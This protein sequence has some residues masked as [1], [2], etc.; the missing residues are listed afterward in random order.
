M[1]KLLTIF[2]IFLSLK[3][4]RSMATHAVGA[5]ITYQCLGGNNYRFF[6]TLYRD[7]SGI[8][9]NPQYTLGG[10]SSC[11]G[12][13]SIIVNLDSTYEV[14]HTCSTVITTCTNS[15]STY[16]GVQANYYHGDITLPS[17]C[18]FWTF[19]LSPAICNRNLAIN[20]LDTSNGF[21]C[22]YVEATLN[23]AAVQCNNSPS[24]S[25]TPLQFLCANQVQYYAQASY[26]VDGDSLTYQMITPHSDPLTDVQYIPGLTA[27]Q[28]VNYID[29][30]MFNPQT[31]DIRFNADG[32]QITVIAILINE[33]RNGVLIGSVERDIELI[34]E[35]CLNNIPAATG[36][37]GTISYSTHVCADSSLSFYIRTTDVD[38]ADQTFL[39]WDGG[40]PGAIFIPS[41]TFRDTGY[42]GWQPGMQDIGAQSHNFYVT[43]TDD[44]CPVFGTSI[45]TYSI[46]VD[47]CF[48]TGIHNGGNLVVSFSANYSS[49]NHDI[50]FRYYLIDPADGFISLYDLTGRKIRQ[51]L[52]PKMASST[53]K[54]HVEGITPGLY[55]LNL[56]TEGGDSKSVKLVID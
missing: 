21:A 2:I 9:V 23:N 34:F 37:N 12:N 25:N 50:D 42:F 41:G 5:E 4:E 10:T 38:L 7:C 53:G 35:N 30:T 6:F 49:N 45:Y 20:N 31:G 18:N 13:V 32:A 24:F 11:G 55:I 46:F 39:S 15:V 3:S 22:L 52:L 8:T 33:F 16:M 47:S 56:K 44:A 26:D 29:S 14:A 36:M 51:M 54:L 1:R 43:V 27:T 19:G 17:V 48:S 28:P 40:I